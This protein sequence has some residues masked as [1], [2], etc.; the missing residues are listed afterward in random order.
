M[1]RS[2]PAVALGLALLAATLVGACSAKPQ[3]VTAPPASAGANATPMATGTSA[4]D[5][6]TYPLGAAVTVGGTSG[7]T[8]RVIKFER[9]PPCKDLSAASGTSLV[10][11]SVDYVPVAAG[12][13]YAMTD[14]TARNDAGTP[15]TPQA[16]CYKD[17]L[18]TG[19]TAA[20]TAQAHTSGW[21]V[22]QVPTASQHLFV[23]YTG[24]AGS[25]VAWQLY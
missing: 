7:V 22:L 12:V 6:G 17:V 23:T 9:N 5:L 21:L 1:T 19:T 20:S 4:G 25:K 15:I 10:G 8:V 13:P 2:I 3:I 11:V 24:T 18:G 16:A 14:W